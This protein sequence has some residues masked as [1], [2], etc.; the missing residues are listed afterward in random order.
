MWTCQLCQREFDD[1][2]I[3]YEIS[4]ALLQEI[5]KGVVTID[6]EPNEDV[7]YLCEDCNREILRLRE[8]RDNEEV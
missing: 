2:E 4:M 7:C 1:T 5:F 6:R 8:E 3:K